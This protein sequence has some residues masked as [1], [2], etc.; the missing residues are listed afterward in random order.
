MILFELRDFLK[1]H[2][3]VSFKQ[4]C[5]HF[6]SSEEA[7]ED[8]LQIWIRKGHLRALDSNIPCGGCTDKSCSRPK[9]F[10]WGK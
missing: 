1:G 5:D 3:T 4:I 7:M 8:M 9:F 2:D 6:E 10:R